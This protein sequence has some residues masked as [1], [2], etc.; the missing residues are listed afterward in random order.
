MTE[1]Q[2]K[3]FDAFGSSALSDSTLRGLPDTEVLNLH[4]RT[5]TIREILDVTTL[6]LIVDGDTGGHNK[7]HFF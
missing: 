1:T 2:L 4:N 6:P 7:Q 3:K 5:A